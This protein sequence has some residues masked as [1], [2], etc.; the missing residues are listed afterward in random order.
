MLRLTVVSLGTRGIRMGVCGTGVMRGTN[1]ESEDG[2][3]RKFSTVMSPTPQLYYRPLSAYRYSTHLGFALRPWQSNPF[4]I[5]PT[6]APFPT[7]REDTSMTQGVSCQR[8]RCIICNGAEPPSVNA[9]NH[10]RCI[11]PGQSRQTRCEWLI[12]SFPFRA[13][14]R[15]NKHNFFAND[16]FAD[17]TTVLKS[18][19]TI[20]KPF[21]RNYP[22]LY[23]IAS[24][25]FVKEKRIRRK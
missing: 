6:R 7:S 25:L 9:H 22:R 5:A 23:A 4:A 15:G 16:I 12:M 8:Q 21:P 20:S 24:C 1:W 11:M 19:R 17:D 18:L 2:F 10:L 3:H 13:T 14:V